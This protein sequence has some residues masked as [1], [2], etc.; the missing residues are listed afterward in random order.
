M[1]S[2]A[3]VAGPIVWDDISGKIVYKPPHADNRKAFLGPLM[4]TLV[5]NA[6][7]Q[8]K[9]KLSSLFQVGWDSLTQKHVLFWMK[10]AQVQKAV[11]SFNVAG[12]IQDTTG[13]FLAINDT[14]FA[15][16]KSNL[17][18]QENVTL[19]VE[20]SKTGRNHSLTLKY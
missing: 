11:E 13:D 1:E 18:V 12:R 15:G 16:A 4:N 20:Q 2:Y 6:M 7:G 19:N 10:D 8:P 17:Y 3:D 9:D 14:N 5:A